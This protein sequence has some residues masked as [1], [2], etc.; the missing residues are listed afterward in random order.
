MSANAPVDT[1][2]ESSNASQELPEKHPSASEIV[3]T[4]DG[5]NDP[6]NPA[7]WPRALKW[8]VTGFACFMCFM[9]GMN[10]L[11]IS[12]A[13]VEIGQEFG[14]SDASFP[15]SYWMV[16]AWN[17]GAALF[18]LVILPLLED[19]SVRIGYLVSRT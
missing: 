15:N 19:F 18:P 9:V 14:I 6:E 1:D 7:C 12:S 2:V 3:A 5:E 16:S 10:A 11:S 8:R 13:A 4:W 17:L